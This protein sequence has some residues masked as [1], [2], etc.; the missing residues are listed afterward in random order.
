M[1]T[2]CQVAIAKEFLKTVSTKSYDPFVS[3]DTKAMFVKDKPTLEHKV[4][5]SGKLSNPHSTIPI[6]EFQE[7]SFIAK[8]VLYAS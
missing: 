8:P 5:S 4:P 6:V 1:A 3:D 7:L 2:I